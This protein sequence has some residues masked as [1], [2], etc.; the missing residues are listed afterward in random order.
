MR[1]VDFHILAFE[2]N[3]AASLA[4]TEL[5]FGPYD[6]LVTDAFWALWETLFHKVWAVWR[7]ENDVPDYRLPRPVSGW[8]RSLGGRP[9]SGRGATGSSCCAVAAR[10]ASSR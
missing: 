5:D 4:P 1:R 3:K 8:W 7:F 6:D 10:T 9:W 2:A